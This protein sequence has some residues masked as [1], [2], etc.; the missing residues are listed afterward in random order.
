MQHVSVLSFM[1]HGPEIMMIQDSNKNINM[2]T[3][4]GLK[5]MEQMLVFQQQILFRRVPIYL[6]FTLTEEL[7]L[8]HNMDQSYCLLVR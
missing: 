2:Q 5:M 6:G 8:D 1:Q 4:L 3:E 7:N